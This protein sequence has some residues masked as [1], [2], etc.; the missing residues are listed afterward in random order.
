MD[1]FGV[2]GEVLG[3]YDSFVKGF[4]DI[5]DQQVRDKVEGEIKNGLLWPAP[6]LAHGP[7]HSE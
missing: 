1:G 2:L 3:G 6:W 4:L 5:Q 7:R